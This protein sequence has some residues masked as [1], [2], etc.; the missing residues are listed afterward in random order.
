MPRGA[1]LDALGALHPVVIHGIERGTI[2][3]DGEDRENDDQDG[4]ISP[5]NRNYNLCYHTLG[6]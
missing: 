3:N 6:G 2:V 1:R 4:R 5:G